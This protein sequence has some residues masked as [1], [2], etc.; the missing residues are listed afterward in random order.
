MDLKT[1][2]DFGE[3]IYTHIGERV[4]TDEDL[5][6]EAIK[7]IKEIN[8]EMDKSEDTIF[9]FGLERTIGWIK[10]FFNITEEEIK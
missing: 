9:I 5:K 4:Y 7:Q 8:K 1:L 6:L 3:T 10:Y 2:K